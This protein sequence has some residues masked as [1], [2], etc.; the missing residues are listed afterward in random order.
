MKVYH[1]HIRVKFEY[2][3]YRAKIKIIFISTCYSFVCGYKS[4]IGSR[5]YT[6]VK[7]TPTLRS[8]SNQDQFQ[9]EVL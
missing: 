3:G 2:Q 7:V 4:L 6:K 5:P 9:G 8:R 1:Y